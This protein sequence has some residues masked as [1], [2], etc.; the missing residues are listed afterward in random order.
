[1]SLDPQ[2]ESTIT[3]NPWDPKF[4]VNPYPHYGAIL[5]KPPQLVKVGAH[6]A[7]LVARYADAVAV[8]HDHENFRSEPPWSPNNQGPFAGSF[9]ILGSDPPRHTRLRRIISRAF[10]PRRVRDLEPR[11]RDFA[12]ASLD[13]AARKGEFDIMSEVANVVPVE[14]IAEMLGVPPERHDTFKDWSDRIVDASS[15][16]IPGAPAMAAATA[17]DAIEAVESAAAYFGEEIEKRRRHPG[18]DLVSALVAAHDEAEALTAMELVQFA[19][20]LLLAGSETTTNLIGNGMLAL[21]R[22]RDQLERLRREPSLLPNAIEEILRF[23]SPVQSTGRFTHS[24]VELGGTQIARGTVMFVINAAANRDPARFPNPDEFDIA[25]TPNDHLAFGDGIHFCIGAPLARLEAQ[26]VF[27]EM[28][29]RV[30]RFELVHPEAPPI[31]KDSYFL[32]GLE[33]LIVATD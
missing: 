19:V 23:D 3:F 24:D 5:A 9:D 27:G 18:P 25:R 11:I 7:V 13:T 32:R 15:K 10:T 31:Y 16:L 1:M 17:A 8:L 21:V 20:T 4:I 14:V 2:Q 26:I 33:S 12:R 6:S 29:A 22:Y 30:P 28:L